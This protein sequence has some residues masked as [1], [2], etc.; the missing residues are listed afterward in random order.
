ML[1]SL[2][3]FG[4]SYNKNKKVS[5]AI[6]LVLILNLL[7]VQFGQVNMLFTMINIAIM[8]GLT[9]GIRKITNKKVNAVMSVLSILVWSV[10]I[11][12]VSY[13]MFPFAGNANIISYILNGII[14]NL[15]FV[16]L[17]ACVL[18]FVELVTYLFNRVVN[19]NKVVKNNVE[20]VN[21]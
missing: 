11:D 18:V 3:L 21:M 16:F 6:S 19:K 8:I 4:G 14:F 12:L 20:I 15:R 10:L 7:I 2:L 5:Y 13:Y 1:N 17:N 9:Y